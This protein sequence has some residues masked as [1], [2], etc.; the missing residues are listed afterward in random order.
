MFGEGL[1][2]I[3]CAAGD[4]EDAF[5]GLNIGRDDSSFSP[6]FVAPEGVDAVIEIV[7][8]GDGVE[9]RL[10]FVVF[11][12]VGVEGIELGIVPGGRTS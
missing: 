3:A 12:G 9:H 8:A 10:D 7:R 4:I 6:G 2:E 1:G 5:A 11:V